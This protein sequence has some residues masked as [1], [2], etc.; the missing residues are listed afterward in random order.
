LITNEAP[1]SFELPVAES[2]LQWKSQC[3]SE[4]VTSFELPV[5]HQQAQVTSEVP[6]SFELPVK[7]PQA[8]VT[9]EVP[10]SFELPVAEST[11]QWK[12]QCY[13]GRF[14][15]LR[16]PV[17]Y[18]QASATSGRVNTTVAESGLEAKSAEASASFCYQ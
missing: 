12:C 14:N 4:R 2:T 9:S 15:K 16:S 18:Q 7:H 13:S 5:K 11:L 1:T 10:A 6:A 8:Q 3:Y 17:K